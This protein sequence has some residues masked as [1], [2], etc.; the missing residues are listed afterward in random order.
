MN[1]AQPA[2]SRVRLSMETWNWVAVIPKGAWRNFWEEDRSP[3]KNAGM[4]RKTRYEKRPAGLTHTTAKPFS[5]RKQPHANGSEMPPK[6]ADK[7][8]RDKIKTLI[9][10]YLGYSFRLHANN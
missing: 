7:T 6:K 9:I 10:S 5:K 2:S 3:K 8:I 1:Q 4:A